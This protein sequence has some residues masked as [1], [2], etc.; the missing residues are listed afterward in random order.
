MKKLLL[1]L[2]IT[3]SKV[4]AD[5][6]DA[7]IYGIPG[8][9]ID[10]DYYDILV[11]WVAAPNIPDGEYVTQLFQDGVAT[12]V[13]GITVTN[14]VCDP[15]SQVVWQI[16][17]P[18][19]FG[20][21]LYIGAGSH[22]YHWEGTGVAASENATLN[23]TYAPYTGGPGG[24]SVHVQGNQT[25]T[26]G[27]P[28]PPTPTPSPT[29]GPT[30]PQD[31]GSHKS[32]DSGSGGTG[33][34]DGNDNNAVTNGG[35]DDGCRHGMARYTVDLMTVSLRITDTPLSYTLPVGP[36]V[37]FTVAY[38]QRDADQSAA[39]Q[40]SNLGQNWTFNWLSYVTD[41]PVNLGANASIYVRGGGTERYSGFNSA[42]QSYLP[43]P[44]SMATL[45]RTSASSY[46]KRF[47]DGSKQV[48]DRSN[49]AAAFP[50]LI[51]MTQATDSSGNTVTIHYDS[52]NR[53]DTITDALGQVTTFSYTLSGD[54]YKITQVTD[55]FGRFVALN[56]TGGK[57]TSTTD[58]VN[59]SSQFGYQAGTNFINSLT[60]PYG[61]VSFAAGEA[62][63]NRW[64]NMTD[65]NSAVERVEYRDSAPGISATDPTA[66]VPTGV[67]FVNA[68]LHYRNTFYWD[69]K[70]LSLYP[71]VN[72][73]YDYTKARITHW[74]RTSDGLL[75]SGI[76]A[77]EKMP[78]ENRVW[79]TYAG[80]P[81]YSRIGPT[82]QPAQVARVLADGTTQLSLFEYNTL[83]NVTKTTDPV[84]RVFTN[85]YATNGI[86]LLEKRQTRNTNND[87]LQRFTYNTQH[88]PLTSVDA[89][90]QGSTFFYNTRG[91]VM[92]A[93]NAKFETTT[94][95]YGAPAPDGYLA[96]VTSPPI[97]GISKVTNYAYDTAKRVRTVTDTDSYS[98]VT[99]YDNLD[100]PM[101]ITYP[102]TTY[103]QF[104]YTDN[105]TGQMTLDVTSIRDRRGQTAYKHYNS[106]KR[107]DK[108]TDPAG[109][110]TLYD[111]CACGSLNS[112]TDPKGQ[113]TTFNRDLEGRVYQKLFNDTTVVNYLYE[114]QTAPNTVG[115]DSRL[116]SSTDAKN[117]RTNYLYFADD[118]LQQISY[119]TTAGQ[120]LTPPTAS[121]SYTYDPNYNRISTMNDGTGLTNYGYYAVTV[122]P[123]LGA[124]QLETLDGPLTNDT[125]YFG[126]DELGRLSA[127]A[128][129][130]L[131]NLNTTSF[132]SLGRINGE[133]NNLGTF[134][135]GYVGVT[136]RLQTLN[137]PNG[138]V[139]SYSY[140][141][142]SGDKQLQTLQNFLPN[143]SNLSRFDYVYDKEH[144]I[145]QWTKQIDAAAST[146]LYLSYDPADQL[147]DWK[148][149]ANPNRFGGF[150]HNLAYDLAGNRQTDIYDL[151]PGGYLGA[152]EDRKDEN[153]NSVN[154]LG[155]VQGAA[156]SPTP[157]PGPLHE[158]EDVPPPPPPDT[159]SYDPNGN[160]IGRVYSSG[161]SNTFE[162][163]AANRL[164]AIT[165]LGGT[166][167][168][169]FTYDGLSHRKKIVEKT[170]GAITSTKQF[171][172]VGDRIAEERDANNVV[173][174]R[175]F[176][177]GEQRIGGTDA[178]L[179]YYAKDHLGNI[180]ELT[181]AAG[182]LRARY[183]YDPFGNTSKVSGDLNLDFGY[184]GHYR[185]A[186]SNL[187]LAPYRAYDPT[188]GRWIS[189]DLIGEAGGLN[190]YGYV[191]NDPLSMIDPLGLDFILLNNSTAVYNVG[192]HNAVL[193]GNNASGWT[194]YSKDGTD[195]GIQYDAL[196]VFDTYAEF[197]GDPL[198]SGYDRA[199]HFPT[200]PDQD[201]AA[202]TYGDN[203]LREPY[204][205]L[206]HNCGDFASELADAA[207][208]NV[209]TIDGE[210]TVPNIQFANTGRQPGAKVW[211]NLHP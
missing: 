189:R 148:N 171:V 158:G 168:T 25:V 68:D 108:E 75:T 153:F 181:D 100:R 201:S 188:I 155:S 196:R 8:N 167:R 172:W 206:H 186:A 202:T 111:W 199:V 102:D 159:F 79:Y 166:N 62:G 145:T 13:R 7:H 194:Y 34:D 193:V 99:D 185:H 21:V 96:S 41:D 45:V 12:E 133:V 66:T 192:G 200:T 113:L 105:V 207:G 204:D 135:F 98:V 72:G 121:V 163:D 123:A 28:P 211:P 10:D 55:P 177:Q 161:S 195:K 48:F 18:G 117:Q 58:P 32:N 190:L 6:Q 24:Q 180:R 42:S 16:G 169:E 19:H 103:K 39:Q 127:F 152:I 44:Q 174:R 170:A 65:A 173:T 162:W 43:D 139:T 115:A 90:G 9:S 88:L 84:G 83:G 31:D 40:Y 82:A 30:P 183:D 23:V 208:V 118:T 56:Y 89:S 164:T 91:Q 197:L 142:N 57:L 149:N 37:E 210:T 176:G 4:Y 122:P 76:A 2:L 165:Y 154:E 11:T 26:V 71:A 54:P 179:Y 63:T 136:N 81:D 137:Y 144:I 64:L 138:R 93:Q 143:A 17:Q 187:Y 51:F 29:P 46:E 61:T 36:K 50:R 38:N 5:A 104:T 146:P 69:K 92:T 140:F 131:S 151:F 53:I 35:D 97:N 22:D 147:V 109:K 132:D 85:V 209:P 95:A 134:S 191:L 119:T 125:V 175:Y 178:G 156:P 73:V 120:P 27:I 205:F 184:T 14:G 70:A 67:G 116:Q 49:G 150:D 47:H 94:Y 198:S 52:S 110:I 101:K 124:G 60:T 33:E 141:P 112:I 86:D 59:I 160:M 203:H 128:V 20:R 129:N 126:Y 15:A 87:L 157:A 107:L 130:G 182:A 80:Q 74:L 78:L 1:L 77:S 106:N 114:G 3:A